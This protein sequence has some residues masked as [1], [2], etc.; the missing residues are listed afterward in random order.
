VRLFRSGKAASITGFPLK[1]HPQRSEPAPRISGHDRAGSA[2]RLE[3]DLVENI[4]DIELR[5]SVYTPA[6]TAVISGSSI[7]VIAAALVA[8]V[9]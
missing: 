1:L 4:V 9:I 8:I 3:I 7:A 2:H 5:N 6:A